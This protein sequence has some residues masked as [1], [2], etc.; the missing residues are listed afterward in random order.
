MFPIILFLSSY[1]R[2]CK[3]TACHLTIVKAK[4][5][6]IFFGL[7]MYDKLG[8]PFFLSSLLKMRPEFM[9]F[10]ETLPDGKCATGKLDNQPKK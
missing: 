2:I 5:D 3:I 6:R 8:F 1:L 7:Q 9:N 4:M 10:L